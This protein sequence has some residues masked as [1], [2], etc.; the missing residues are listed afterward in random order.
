MHLRV[1]SATL[2]LPLQ[3][4]RYGKNVG[5]SAVQEA[6]ASIAHYGAS[7]AWVVTNSHFTDAAIALAKS[8][9]TL[10]NRNQ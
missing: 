5:I 9:V 7:E 6:Q 4:K 8:T 3:A 10:I 1:V 2:V